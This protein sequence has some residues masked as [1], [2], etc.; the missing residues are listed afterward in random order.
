M[1]ATQDVEMEVVEAV[2]P[3]TL[4]KDA[5]ASAV[6]EIREHAKQIDKAV[7]SKEPRFILRVLRSLPNTRRKLNPNVLR[8]LAAQ[9]YPVGNERESILAFV[10]ELPAGSVEPE[11]VRPRAAI[12]TPL[13][14]V[15]AY[16]HLLALVRLLD[17][18]LIDKASNCGKNHK[19]YF[20]DSVCKSESTFSPT[21]DVKNHVPEPQIS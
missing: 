2:D 11:V 18:N 7:A 6:Q 10:E 1:V 12:K 3:E 17:A 19:N 9:L 16:Y 20:N 15:D 21:A 13:P 5:D 4:K 14:E 8:A